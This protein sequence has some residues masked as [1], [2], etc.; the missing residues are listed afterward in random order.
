MRYLMFVIPLV[1]AACGGGETR[2]LPR[3]ETLSVIATTPALASMA[4]AI[5]GDDAKVELFGPE[6]GSSHD[7]EPSVNDRRRLE[8]AHVLLVNGMGLEGF[9]TLKVAKSARIL[10]VNCSADMP[11]EYLIGSIETEDEHAGHDHAHGEHNP[12]VWLGTEG[13]IHQAR[14]ITEALAKAD[15]AHADGY[16]SRFEALKSRLEALVAEYKP[17][18][19]ALTKKNFVSNHDAFPYFAREFGLKQVGVIQR[20]PGHNPTVEQRRAIEKMLSSG[21][22]HAIFMEPGYDDAASRIIAENSK[23]PLGVLDPFDVGKPSTDGLEKVM[24]AN[25]DTVLKTLGR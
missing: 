16:R 25:L 14:A 7:F 4:L 10:H 1:L 3:G 8:T 19:A 22:A 18:V 23:L 15:P 21:H 13:A 17:K 20:T 6:G 9:D 2:T 11:K 24:R 12:H 5:A